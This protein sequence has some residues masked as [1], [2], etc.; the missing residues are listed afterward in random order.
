M[1]QTEQ[2]KRNADTKLKFMTNIDESD[3]ER[4]L[5]TTEPAPL[6]VSEVESDDDNSSFNSDHDS[7]PDWQKLVY[8]RLAARDQT[9]MNAIMLNFEKTGIVDLS[10]ID[11]QFLDNFR[12]AF[13]SAQQYLRRKGCVDEEL[14]NEQFGIT[15]MMRILSGRTLYEEPVCSMSLLDQ[16]KVTDAA[17]EG[18]LQMDGGAPP[19]RNADVTSQTMIRPPYASQVPLADRINMYGLDGCESGASS[20]YEEGDA[21]DELPFLVDDFDLP[22]SGLQSPAKKRNVENNEQDQ[23]NSSKRPRVG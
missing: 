20:D 7:F 6:I 22:Y 4:K 19:L 8:E 15:S 21:A 2:R 14:V 3:E 18:A 23:S 1:L 12:A 5:G 16:L 9:T 11:A 17:P 13:V 10:T